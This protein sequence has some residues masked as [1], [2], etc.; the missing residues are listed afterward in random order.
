[1]TGGIILLGLGVFFLLLNFG[2]LDWDSAW[3]LV[4]VIVGLALVFGA[5][6]RH[7]HNPQQSSPPPSS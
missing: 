1:M 3:P 7:D 5:F 2:Y 6:R 4:L